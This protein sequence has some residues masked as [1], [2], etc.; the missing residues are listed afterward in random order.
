MTKSSKKSEKPGISL[1]ESLTAALSGGASQIQRSMLDAA[2]GKKPLLDLAFGDGRVPEEDITA[3]LSENLRRQF[4]GAQ[5]DG[6]N[7]F[8]VRT[9]GAHAAKNYVCARYTAGEFRELVMHAL[10]RETNESGLDM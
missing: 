4:T 3:M 9:A 2:W 5:H 6:A 1:L 10:V 8:S 7:P